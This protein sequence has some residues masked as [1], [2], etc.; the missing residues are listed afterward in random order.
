MCAVT[1]A[2]LWLI[3]QPNPDWRLLDWSIGIVV[4]GILVFGFAAVGG[5]KWALH[6]GFSAAFVLTAVPWPSA[7]EQPVMQGLMRLVA[8]VTSDLLNA[9][10]IAAVP[11][12]S[13]I[14]IKAGPLGVSEACSGVRSLQASLMAALF[15]GELYRF[16]AWQRTTLFGAGMAL[17]LVC[18]V[19]RTYFLASRAAAE[20]MDAIGR[21]HDPAG[22][23]VLTICFAL[24]WLAALA[25]LRGHTEPAFADDIPPAPPLPRA[26]IWTLAVWFV[27]VFA[28]T[29]AWFRSG[30]EVRRPSWQFTFPEQ[31]VGFRK[32]ELPAETLAQL[33]ADYAQTG[34]WRS[35]SGQWLA[36]AFRWDA[37]P[38]RSRILARLHRPENCLPAM[39]WGLLEERTPIE[40]EVG[41]GRA[42]FR[43]MTFVRDDKKA[44][45]YYCLWQDRLAGTT[46]TPPPSEDTRIASLRAVARRERNLGQQVVEIVFSGTEDGSSADAAFRREIGT[47]LLPAR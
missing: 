31:R 16:R 29:E 23:T 27:L 20:G 26:F 44:H 18:N 14:Q 38:S 8:G 40:I 35:D 37:G 28:G 4:V 41:G 36:F 43:V 7:V 34:A 19:G 3:A 1:F 33:Q 11:Q 15:L 21:Y 17:A 9:T 2:P 24:L 25:L 39:G 5:A 45:V 47:T 32:I 46:D 30:G 10:G 6:F 42:L 22:F 12:G 13:I